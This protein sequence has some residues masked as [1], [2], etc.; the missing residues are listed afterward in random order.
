MPTERLRVKFHWF[1]VSWT[2]TKL[3]CHFSCFDYSSFCF[4]GTNAFHVKAENENLIAADSR[5]RQNLK[6]KNFT[7]SFGRLHKKLHQKWCRTCSTIIFPHAI[8]QIINLWHCRGR[9]R[10]F[11][12]S[13][14]KIVHAL[15]LMS[16]TRDQSPWVLSH[17]LYRENKIYMRKRS[18]RAAF[19]IYIQK[20]PLSDW[21][22]ACQL[23]PNSAKTWNFLSGERRN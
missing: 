15:F 5:C 19:I 22:R 7:S 9:C 20:F 8:N 18:I 13:L 12:N 21:Q 6:Y 10:H 14:L 1:L 23:I 17:D 3:P 16:K 4:F 11:L 2:P